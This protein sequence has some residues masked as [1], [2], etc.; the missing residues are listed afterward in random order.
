[1]R[2]KMKYLACLM[3]SGLISTPALAV[4]I[5]DEPNHKAVGNVRWQKVESVDVKALS[6]RPVPHGQASLFFVREVSPNHTQTS[7]NIAVNDRF[8]VSLQPGNF[9][10]VNSCAGLNDLSAKI[11][12]HK[13]NNLLYQARRV[14]LQSQ[15]SYFFFV[16]V[17]A[18]GNASID[19]ITHDSA[20]N[21]I[22]TNNLQ[23]QTHQI[24]RVVQNVCSQPLAPAPVISQPAPAPVRPVAKTPV[25]IELAVL[26]DTDKSLVKPQYY[27]EIG[28]VAH[29][30]NQHPN[31]TAVIEGHTD[32]R[33]TEE[34]NQAL[35]Q[36]RVDAVKMVLINEYQIDPSRL[37]SVGYGETRPIA[38]NDTR[39]GRQQNRRVVATFSGY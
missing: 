2:T 35:S 15:G 12:G 39:E 16:K 10:Q 29:F 3:V 5:I 23:Y 6:E 11:T 13:S 24:S 20:I 33:Q 31:V 17:D 9:S 8:Q 37:S 36:R 27:E 22:T 38:T 26:F 21:Y 7:V 14:D 34:Y 32:S 28:R 19:P 1:M 30:M 4:T 18:Q 25:S